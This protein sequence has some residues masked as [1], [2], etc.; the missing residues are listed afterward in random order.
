MIDRSVAERGLRPARTVHEPFAI[1]L[2][3]LVVVGGGVSERLPEHVRRLGA[4]RVL[5]VTDSFLNEHGPIPA[6]VA[7]LKAAGIDA[8]VFHDVQPDP[9]TGNVRDG[10]KA[11][12]RHGAEAVVAVGGGSPID[13]AKA[14]AVMANRDGSI[15]D[16]A[17]YDRIG[18]RGLPLV[19]IPT[20]A[21]SG[22][23]QTR[24]TVIADTERNLKLA[25]YDDALLP[26]VALVD[27]KLSLSQPRE[28][29]AHV[30]LDALVHAVEAY[31]SRLATPLSDALAIEA[32]RL[33]WAN[34]RTAFD[35]PH[36]EPA[37]AAV[38]YGASVAGA[39]FSNSSV[40][41]VHGMSRPI[42]ANFH[43]AHGLANAL[44]FSSVTRFGLESSGGRYARLARAIGLA[45]E[46]SSDGE[47]N[48]ALIDGLDGLVADLEI[49]TMRDLGVSETEYEA[50]LPA[51]ADAALAS[52]SPDFNPRQ[53]T[54]Q[55]IIDLYREAY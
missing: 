54:K 51:M 29:T 40:C 38:M 34:L 53:P 4:G 18:G 50:A 7:G 20:T 47:A 32:A 37:R 49:P 17:G 6:V 14:I 33:V 9:T 42:G 31:V 27:Y 11:L 26:L 21:G 35:S 41:L 5:V 13:A 25:I 8:A 12:H 2:P 46:A 55:E 36:D 30:G 22:S 23:E 24:A 48:A 1:K 45:D 19:A 16:Y 44:L 39:A 10:L 15:A 3:P 52:G 28:L 43:I